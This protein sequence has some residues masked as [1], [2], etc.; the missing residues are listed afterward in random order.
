MTAVTLVMAY[1]ENPKMLARQFVNIRALPDMLKSFLSVIV[2]DDASPK[3]PAKAENLGSVQLK[4]FRMRVDVPWNQDACRNIGMKNVKTEWALLT[5]MD[6]IVPSETWRTVIMGRWD[7]ECVYRFRR[8]N[9]PDM[10]PYKTHLN[11][12]LITKDKF[13][14]SGCYDERFAGM[15]Q[16]HDFHHRLAQFATIKLI[17]EPIICVPSSVVP[18]AN[19]TTYKRHVDVEAIDRIKKERGTKRPIRY[20]FEYDRVY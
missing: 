1:Y 18:D 9:E 8:V 11:S 14:E 2:V 16:D 6:H 12:Y 13:Y 20:Q 10:K 17:D 19:T 7:R 4:M 15:Y 5:D 3:S